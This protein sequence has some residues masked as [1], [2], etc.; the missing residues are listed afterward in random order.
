[1]DVPLGITTP[2]SAIALIDA[3]K[4]KPIAMTSKRR[5]AFLPASWPTVAE[6][7]YDVDAVLWIGVFA[8]TGT[9]APIVERVA[10]GL[11]RATADAEVRDRLNTTGIEAETM[12]Q[13]QFGEY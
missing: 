7:G 11:A 9:P 5:P 8:P 1:G 12:V 4:V 2:S 10:Q 13:P 6:S 3:K